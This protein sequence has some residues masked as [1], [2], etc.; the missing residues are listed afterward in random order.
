MRGQQL[1]L[2]KPAAVV[3][4]IVVVLAIFFGQSLFYT[5]G[6]K[7]EVVVQRFGAYSRTT[8]SG[9]HFKMPYPF[10][11]VTAVPTKAVRT[12]EFGF[13]TVMAGKRTQYRDTTGG[14]VVMARQ[15]TGDLNLAHIE[16]TVQWKVHSAKDYLFS[17]GGDERTQE[18]NVRETISDVSEKVVR[19]I[20]GDI[21]VDDAVT[22][23][24]EQV[25]IDAKIEIQQLMDGFNSG[26]TIV[27][28]DVQKAQ[29][30][31]EK[32]VDAWESV[33]RARQEKDRLVNVALAKRN[34]KIP[35]ARGQKERAIK[36]AKGYAT[37]ITEAAAGRAE[38]F[39][40]QAAEHDKAPE[41]TERRLY[42][43]AME[44]IMR[45]ADVTVI[46]AGLGRGA[47]PFMNLLNDGQPKP[48]GK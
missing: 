35:A 2:A 16:W 29:P 18:D 27:K 17:V 22:T 4:I 1:D 45:D 9:L 38:A 37:R 13:G 43:E 48:V 21:S 23:G 36:E 31:T 46:D 3:G 26:V 39:L 33:N 42:I 40:A 24:R 10:E 20:I 12:V 7:E 34:D 32:V 5:V 15:V 14:D 25:G 8:G 41:M 44:G 47:V 19:R 11:T 6:P 30:P 28:V